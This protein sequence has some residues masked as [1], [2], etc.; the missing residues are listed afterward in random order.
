MQII[1]QRNNL[2]KFLVGYNINIKYSKINKIVIYKNKINYF[3]LILNI[4]SLVILLF[5]TNKTYF[6]PIEDF[7]IY[8]ILL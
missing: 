6:K 2:Y 1:L 8:K 5:L 4:K 3:N 7:K